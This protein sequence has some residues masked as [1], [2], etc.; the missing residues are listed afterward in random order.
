M[1]TTTLII[2][3]GWV[4]IVTY[5]VIFSLFPFL[6]II[7]PSHH[8]CRFTSTWKAFSNCRLWTLAINMYLKIV[9]KKQ[10]KNDYLNE[11]TVKNFPTPLKLR[12]TRELYL[13]FHSCHFQFEIFS[14]IGL[15]HFNV[16]RKN[17]HDFDT[18]LK[19]NK[20]LYKQLKS[21][22]NTCILSWMKRLTLFGISRNVWFRNMHPD[23][24]FPSSKMPI[25]CKSK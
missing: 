8:T 6:I 20:R 13:F 18:G 11:W 2:I 19:S 7:L 17:L 4:K 22:L 15:F 24:N 25:S 5:V 9:S 3:F 21:V 1:I 12:I 23:S 14:W 16:I 10:R